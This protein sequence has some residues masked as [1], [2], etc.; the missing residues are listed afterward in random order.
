MTVAHTLL[1]AG[2]GAHHYAFYDFTAQY[3]VSKDH[4]EKDRFYGIPFSPL[5][6]AALSGLSELV[7]MLLAVGAEVTLHSLGS[8]FKIESFEVF[9]RLLNLGALP[10]EEIVRAAMHRDTDS[11]WRLSILARH[12]YAQTKRVAMIEAIKL[13]V[14]STIEDILRSGRFDSQKSWTRL[15]LWQALSRTVAAKVKLM[16]SAEFLIAHSLVAL[17][18]FRLSGV[19]SRK[20][21]EV[22]LMK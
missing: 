18:L 21:Y 11:R 2:A 22:P 12:Q 20:L 5:D 16:S 13:G 10:S 3:S 19:L 9:Q 8:A 7:D 6:L 15:R 14:I 4:T 1:E 17:R